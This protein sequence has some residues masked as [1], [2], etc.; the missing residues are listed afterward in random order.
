[1]TR[2][3]LIAGVFFVSLTFVGLL[4]LAAPCRSEAEL[5][6]AVENAAA[7]AEICIVEG[8]YALTKTLVVPAEGVTI[9]GV[10]DDGTTPADRTRVVLDGGGAQRVLSCGKQGL[11]LRDLT[12]SNGCHTVTAADDQCGGGVYAS[13]ASLF[14]NCVF[15]CNRALGGSTVDNGGGAVGLGSAVNTIFRDCLFES[16]SSVRK[17]GALHSQGATTGPSL[18]GCT[19]RGNSA[20]YYGG[21][22]STRNSGRIALLSSCHF[23]GNESADLGGAVQV[24]SVGLV[25]NC[26][27]VANVSRKNGG[28]F[29]ADRA[30]KTTFV[31]CHFLTNAAQP[32]VSSGLT[33]MGG[34]IFAKTFG[35]GRNNIALYGCL[36]E[37]NVAA[38]RGGA[39]ASESGTYDSANYFSAVSYA[40]NTVFR[41]NCATW[42]GAI[43]GSFQHLVDCRFV[44][45]IQTNGNSAGGGA[46]AYSGR[47]IYAEYAE[48][49]PLAEDCHFVSNKCVGTHSV[50]NTGGTVY[51]DGGGAVFG[52]NTDAQL[53][54]R[55]CRF[56]ANETTNIV[57]G[58]FNHATVGAGVFSRGAVKAEDC[59]FERNAGFT[60][61]SAIFAGCVTGGLRQCTFRENVLRAP[62]NVVK[63]SGWYGRSSGTV[64]LNSAGVTNVIENCTFLTNTVF[65]GDGSAV[66]VKAGTLQMTGC[67]ME[68]NLSL[69]DEHQNYVGGAVTVESAAGLGM[70]RCAFVRNRTE[71]YNA[72]AGG[73]LVLRGG[74]SV[75][76]SL[77]QGNVAT[78]AATPIKTTGWGGGAYATD[79]P[80]EFS[81]CTFVGNVARYLGGG[82][83]VGKAGGVTN[84]VF[85]G[86][87]QT[88]ASANGTR[89][90]L[91]AATGA[92]VASSFA[93]VTTQG[94]MEDGVNGCIVRDENPF[95]EDRYGSL[96]VKGGSGR[97]AG[98]LLGWM[99]ASA[100]DLGGH[101]RVKNGAVDFG[102][103]EFQ[104]V[105]GFM[106]LLSSLW[107]G[108][109]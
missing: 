94:F 66:F 89:D 59:V 102:C 35:T 46:I 6:A 28:A 95:C 68:G 63:N 12:V 16:N 97:D 92:S 52:E 54:F 10:A 81:N 30:S 101:V 22:I 72:A 48:C 40:T 58:A 36:F 27:F 32:T 87:V 49:P 31:D 91:G 103:Y 74:G 88:Y 69:D 11:V 14:S 2:T 55:R 17:G 43:S 79:N 84:C 78:N 73:G 107:Q 83:K 57:I 77:F 38:S 90:D 9:R 34:A 47:E 99:T 108:G 62:S 61:G 18:F 5:Q 104:P 24:A 70:D 29:Y 7:D 75:R 106:L 76:N 3:H 15:T 20:G 21:A 82:L 80:V 86:N 44:E 51:Y 64:Y 8:T 26:T 42:G 100:R 65:G 37:G 53:S 25:S 71:H 39:I 23:D 45:N 56:V 67:R 98:R 19:F 85:Y 109:L 1:M 33:G 41:G 96:A 13:S 4:A 93:S 50:N 60:F 105:P